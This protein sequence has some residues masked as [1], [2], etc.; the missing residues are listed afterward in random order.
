MYERANRHRVNI[1]GHSQDGMTPRWALRFWP[2]TRSMVNNMVGLAP[3]K[4]GIDRQLSDDD[5]SPWI[6]ARWQ[7]AHGSQVMCAFNSFQETFDDQI[8]YT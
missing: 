3:A 1:I 2:D 8:S 5:L 4:H 7:F 6:P